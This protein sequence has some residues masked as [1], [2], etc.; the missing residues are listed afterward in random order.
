MSYLSVAEAAQKASL[1]MTYHR[2]EDHWKEVSANYKSDADKLIKQLSEEARITSPSKY[3]RE[4][5]I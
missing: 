5:K 1:R 2:A 3:I 4:F